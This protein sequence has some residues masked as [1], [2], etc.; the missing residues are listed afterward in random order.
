MNKKEYEAQM[1]KYHFALQMLETEINILLEDFKFKNNYNAVEHIKSRIKTIE[2]A[3][4]KLEKRN[5]DIT[6]DNLV[7]HVHDMIGIRIVCSFLSDVKDIV[8][9]IHNSKQLI[10][11]EEK[12]YITIPKET[13]Y[14]SYHILVYVPV[15]LNEETE[16][17]EAEIQIRTMAMDFWATLDHKIRYKFD[18]IIPIE[19]QNEMYKCSLDIQKL[20]KKM[21]KLSNITKK[22]TDNK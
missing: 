13:G 6:L 20:D 8:K 19:V 9:V 10:I 5:L 7:K 1:L 12:D 2:S 4:I 16:Y 21:Q 3:T 17:I 11:K 14:I 22:Y 15:F 18:D